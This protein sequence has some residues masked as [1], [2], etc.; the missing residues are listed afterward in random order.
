MF[1]FV[2]MVLELTIFKST[3]MKVEKDQQTLGNN[4]LDGERVPT[5]TMLVT[6]G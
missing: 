3:S 5:D 2:E 1:F 6:P 4:Y